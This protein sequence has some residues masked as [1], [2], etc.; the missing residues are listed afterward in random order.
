MYG[1]LMSIPDELMP[2]Y[3]E[4]L[5]DLDFNKD[6]NNNENIKKIIIPEFI[7]TFIT[8]ILGSYIFLFLYWY[9]KDK[10]K[11]NHFIQKLLNIMINN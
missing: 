7:A 11:E 8:G 3:Y 9:I 6:N 10:F 1:K 5:C 2:R 4:L